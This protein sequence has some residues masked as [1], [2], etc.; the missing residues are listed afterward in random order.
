MPE[1][2]KRYYA[3]VMHGTIAETPGGLTKKDIKVKKDGTLVSKKKSK[4][5]SENFKPWL[6]AVKQAKYNLGFNQKTFIT[7]NAGEDGKRLYEETASI[8]YR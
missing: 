4:Q 5:A 1:H 6:K 3:K 8:Y 7:M 2:R